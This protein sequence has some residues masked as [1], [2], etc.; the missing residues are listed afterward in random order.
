VAP[1][2]EMPPIP[3]KRL[4]IWPLSMVIAVWPFAAIAN[5]TTIPITAIAIV[6]VIVLVFAIARRGCIAGLLAAMVGLLLL[7]CAC[8][9]AGGRRMSLCHLFLGL[10]CHRKA[11]FGWH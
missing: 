1:P 11:L 10:Y 5:P 7:V 3:Q 8:D 9:A 6:I 2:P 4:P